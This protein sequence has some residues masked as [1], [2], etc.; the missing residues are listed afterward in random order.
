MTDL[1]QFLIPPP[2]DLREP[3]AS[4]PIPKPLKK[5]VRRVLVLA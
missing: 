3:H 5:G 1:L 4:H 2:D